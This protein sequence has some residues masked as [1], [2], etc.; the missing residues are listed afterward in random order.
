MTASEETLPAVMHPVTRITENGTHLT[1]CI[2]FNCVHDCFSNRRHWCLASE[3]KVG[4]P[5]WRRDLPNLEG[6]LPCRNLAGCAPL[7]HSLLH[8]R[9]LSK[10]PGAG[11]EPKIKMLRRNI[12]PDD[13]PLRLVLGELTAQ[14]CAQFVP[15]AIVRHIPHLRKEKLLD[16]KIYSS[17]R[18]ELV[19]GSVAEMPSV[20]GRIRPRQQL[21]AL[22]KRDTQISI[23]QLRTK[24]RIYREIVAIMHDKIN[25]PYI[26]LPVWRITRVEQ[27]SDYQYCTVRWTIDDTSEHERY[28]GLLKKALDD[29]AA[30]IRFQL[31]HRL[32]LRA[33]PTVR[34]LYEDYSTAI[35]TNDIDK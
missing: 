3:Q 21:K 6:M 10:V 13:T 4:Y 1:F 26:K 29:C 32:S 33:A 23:R 2:Q 20:A 30:V 27:S 35:F 31:A 14:T 12:R 9:S 15:D 11:F 24:E 25:N 19:D 18:V 8:S 17:R 34:F 28:F 22:E 5:R 7:G 16:D